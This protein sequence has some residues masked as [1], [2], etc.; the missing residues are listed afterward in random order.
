MY[1]PPDDTQSAD[2]DVLEALAAS[3]SEAGHHLLGNA[4]SAA[5][6]DVANLP[7]ATLRSWHVA[8]L[9]VADYLRNALSDK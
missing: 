8:T 6:A 2:A 7:H 4:R 5:S 9:P 1:A 3:Q